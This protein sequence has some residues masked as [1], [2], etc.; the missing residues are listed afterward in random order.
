MRPLSALVMREKRAALVVGLTVNVVVV[1]RGA[2]ATVGI[3]RGAGGAG[4]VVGT[5]A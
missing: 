4:A 2:G 5:G 1:V 3:T